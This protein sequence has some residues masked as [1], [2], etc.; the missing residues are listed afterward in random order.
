MSVSLSLMC[1][2]FKEP[3]F[4][5]MLGA[6]NLNVTEIG[7]VFSIDTITYSLTSMGLNFV[8]EERNGMKYGLIQFAGLLF[9]SICM[10]M[11]GP[12]PFMAE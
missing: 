5:L 11:S 7:L 3:V 6:K 2:T 9:F 4:A 8:K 1:L 10:L 12:A